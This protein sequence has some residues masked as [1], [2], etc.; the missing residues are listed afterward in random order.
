MPSDSDCAEAVEKQ[1]ASL[2]RMIQYINVVPNKS[3]TINL[4]TPT[5]QVMKSLQMLYICGT[6]TVGYDKVSYYTI[7]CTKNNTFKPHVNTIQMT[8]RAIRCL[9]KNE[10]A[11]LR[12]VSLS[13]HG[14]EWANPLYP[15][16]TAVNTETDELANGR[17]ACN[18]TT[19]KQERE[20]GKRERTTGETRRE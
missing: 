15:T 18:P 17:G 7:I 13:N 12:W 8:C 14:K 9:S 2:D 10:R 3:T 11:S 20:R 5:S 4:K 6:K 19:A 16:V 1:R